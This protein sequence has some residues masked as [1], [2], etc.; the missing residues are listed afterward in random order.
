[1]TTAK[2]R[3]PLAPGETRAYPVLPLRDIV[4][5]PHMIAPIFV[6]GSRRRT[7]AARAET[8]A[9]RQTPGATGP[10]SMRDELAASH[11]ITSSASAS[12]CGG[13]STSNAF[14]VAR[15]ITSS[16]LAPSST[17]RSPGFSPLRI[18]PT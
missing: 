7:A 13:I 17:G 8:P 11:S 6:G 4:V 16:N 5:F 3:P 9:N 10:K 15:L 18:R 2:P 14:A 1:M 12:S